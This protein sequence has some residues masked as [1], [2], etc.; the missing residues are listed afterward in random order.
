MTRLSSLRR[1]VEGTTYCSPKTMAYAGVLCNIRI[2]LLAGVVYFIHSVHAEK[3][4]MAVCA[5]HVNVVYGGNN[6]T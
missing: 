1:R 5:G 4:L 2:I 6:Q 3:L